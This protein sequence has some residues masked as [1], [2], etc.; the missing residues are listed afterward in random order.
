[1]NEE[2]SEGLIFIGPYRLFRS[3]Q[4]AANDDGVYMEPDEHEHPAADVDN[5]WHGNDDVNQPQY[6]D[7]ISTRRREG[8]MMYRRPYADVAEY[9]AIDHRAARYTH[10][11]V[12]DE[13][14]V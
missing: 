4:D 5:G 14:S 8:V 9:A 3:V 10:L 2:K 1:L 12:V 6:A 11:V 13:P 7:V